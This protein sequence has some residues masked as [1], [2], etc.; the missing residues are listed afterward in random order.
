MIM[1]C[2]HCGKQLDFDQPYQIHAGFSD[3]GFLYNEAGSLTLI[4]SSFDPIFEKVCGKNHPWTLD[5]GARKNFESILLPAPS[6]GNWSFD[7]PL[8]CLHCH[9]PI[10][11]PITKTI[12]YFAYEGSVNTE[13]PKNNLSKWVKS[14]A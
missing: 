8:R 3:Q 4:W 2:I 6:G 14:P 1:K 12:Y 13:E 9:Q 7:Y 10:S 11:D 5:E